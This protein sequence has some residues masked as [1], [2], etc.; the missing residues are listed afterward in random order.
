MHVVTVRYVLE[1]HVA[2]DSGWLLSVEMRI[3]TACPWIQACTCYHFVCT[4][5]GYPKTYVTNFSWLFPTPN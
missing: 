2:T 3:V 1:L 4:Y 5:T